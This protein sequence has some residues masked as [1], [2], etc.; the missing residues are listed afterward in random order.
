MGV[1]GGLGDRERVILLTA[2]LSKSVSAA[3]MDRGATLQIRQ[4]E[5]HPAVATVGGSEQR[6]QGLVLID[7]QELPVAEGPAFRR[8]IEAENPDLG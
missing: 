3:H 1:R 7:G 2:Q 5:I 8:K 6:E 4:A